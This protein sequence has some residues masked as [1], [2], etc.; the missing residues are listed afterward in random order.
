[1]L[2]IRFLVVQREAKRTQK[3]LFCKGVQFD[4]NFVSGEVAKTNHLPF[5]A[6][7]PSMMLLVHKIKLQDCCANIKKWSPYPLPTTQL[8][9]ALLCCR[10]RNNRSDYVHKTCVA[11]VRHYS[12]PLTRIPPVPLIDCGSFSGS[13]TSQLTV[14]PYQG[15]RY[16]GPLFCRHTVALRS[17]PPPPTASPC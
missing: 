13:L 2:K 10:S 5:A 17:C 15:M 8:P 14:L 7:R 6:R 3:L 9:W 12:S 1:M 11:H 4:K 16:D